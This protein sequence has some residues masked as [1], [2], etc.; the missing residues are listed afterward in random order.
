[1][2]SIDTDSFD[3]SGQSKLKTRLKGLTIFSPTLSYSP[4]AILLW[5]PLGMFVIHGKMSKDQH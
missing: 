5:M 2:A 1:M 3:G 4:I